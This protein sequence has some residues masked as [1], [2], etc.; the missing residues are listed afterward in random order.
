MPVVAPQRADL[1]LALDIGLVVGQHQ[2]RIV[3]QQILHERT[4]QCV[5]PPASAPEAMKSSTSRNVP[6][7]S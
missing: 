5:S 4:E 7:C 6:F 3:L 1:L 2:E